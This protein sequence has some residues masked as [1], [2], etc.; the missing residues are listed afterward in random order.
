MFFV[1]NEKKR[2]QKLKKQFNLAKDTVK[3]LRKFEKY[4][5]ILDNGK[6]A[7]NIKKEDLKDNNDLLRKYNLKIPSV[8]RIMEELKKNGINI[9]VQDFTIDEVIKKIIGEINEKRS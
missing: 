6:I 3:P 9:E 7:Q 1:K 8:L 2:D 4:S 5:I